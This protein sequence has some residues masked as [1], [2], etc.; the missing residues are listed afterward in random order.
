MN[1]FA[2]NGISTNSFFGRAVSTAGDINGD[3]KSDL[4]F[5]AY[6]VSSQAGAV[7]VIFGQ[8]NFPSSFNLTSL[9]GANG[10]VVNGISSYDSLGFS[11]STAGDINGDGKADLMLGAEG[12]G[13]TGK[14]YVIFGQSSFTSPFNLISLNGANGFVVNEISKGNALGASVSMVGD[15]NGWLFWI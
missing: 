8:T 7:Y 15:I 3:Y 13:N 12:V 11:V 4:V 2:V 14:V 1:G 9:N 5:G 10:F 6:G